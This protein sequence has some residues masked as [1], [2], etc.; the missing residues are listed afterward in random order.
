MDREG[1]EGQRGSR[2][3]REG[4]RK[5]VKIENRDSLARE[6]EKFSRRIDRSG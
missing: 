1:F 6:R 5:R 4:N 2:W 3:R